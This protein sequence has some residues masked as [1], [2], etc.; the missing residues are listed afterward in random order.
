MTTAPHALARALA[1]AAAPL[2]E[3]EG[4]ARLASPYAAAD[5]ALDLPGAAATRRA[6][7][8]ASFA[9][10]H[11]HPRLLLVAEA[12]GPHGARFSG[13]PLTIEAQL[14]DPDFPFDGTPTSVDAAHGRPLD[15][16]SARI[17]QRVIGDARRSVVIW[18]AV[19][20]HPHREG[21][22]RSIRPPTRREVIRFAPALAAVVAAVR[23]ASP[24]AP[25]V[26][27]GR[28]AERALAGIGTDAVYLRHPSQGGARIFADGLRRLLDA[29]RPSDLRPASDPP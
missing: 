26:A 20:F 29:P 28:V 14:L 4:D 3:M 7:L 16:Y 22:P 25:I 1:A 27:V 5:P 12:P 18:N 11:P 21:Q 10:L 13:V 23:A 9:A 15:E 8:L 19:P 6:N 24:A 17:V 2:F